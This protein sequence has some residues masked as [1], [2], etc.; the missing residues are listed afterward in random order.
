MLS[1]GA[2]YI[3][4]L[5]LSLRVNYIKDLLLSL[6]VNYIKNPVDGVSEIGFDPLCCV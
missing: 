2:N 5:L 6:R 3:K 4:D 1:L